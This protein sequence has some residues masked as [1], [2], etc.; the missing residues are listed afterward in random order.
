MQRGAFFSCM[1]VQRLYSSKVTLLRSF[2]KARVTSGGREKKIEHHITPR[3]N[4]LPSN[5]ISEKE[6]RKIDALAACCRDVLH[7]VRGHLWNGSDHLWRR[8]RPRDIGV[9]VSTGAVVLAYGVHDRGTVERAAAGRRLLRLG[10]AG[11]G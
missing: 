11:A 9:A 3:T 4:S 6:S 2:L 7:G 10:A 5:S 1:R 8:L